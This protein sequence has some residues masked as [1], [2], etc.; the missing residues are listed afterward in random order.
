[1]GAEQV[2]ALITENIALVHACANRFRGRGAEYEELFS[3]GCV[4]LC[5]AARHFDPARGFA[6]STYAVPVILGEIRR[7]FRDGGALKV[8]RTLKEKARRAMRVKAQLETELQREVTI[9]ELAERLGITAAEAAQLVTVSMPVLSL[10]GPDEQNEKQMD[11]PVPPP[12][13]PLCDSL[14]LETVLQKLPDRDEKLI[15]LRYFDGLT[16]SK[17]AAQLGMSQVQVSRREKAIL[18]FLREQML[19]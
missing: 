1:M 9:G 2:D 10:T 4:G 15:R 18:L 11:V 5:K 12:E 17:T 16:Q 13:G 19:K 6:F 14:A 8:G 7:V 3:A